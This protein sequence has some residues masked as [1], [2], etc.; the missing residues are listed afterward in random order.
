MRC[1]LINY[2][3]FKVSA[4]V[5]MEIKEENRSSYVFF[6][7]SFF[8]DFKLHFTTPFSKETRQKNCFT[9]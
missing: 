5:E 9:V 7:Y 1:K 3:Y 2:Y 4:K 8:I 6:V